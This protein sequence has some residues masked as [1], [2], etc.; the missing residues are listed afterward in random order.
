LL[1]PRSAYLQFGPLSRS[2]SAE[3]QPSQRCPAGS[4][5][6]GLRALGRLLLGAGAEP[7]ECASNPLQ[8]IVR[9]STLAGCLEA[10]R[11]IE[12][13]R[14]KWRQRAYAKELTF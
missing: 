5:S 6:L 4:K 8:S 13:S 9:V 12:G 1:A 2:L 11:E 14:L 7:T 3:L 10:A